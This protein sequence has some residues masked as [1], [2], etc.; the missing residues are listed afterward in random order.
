MQSGQ[1]Q[2]NSLLAQTRQLFQHQGSN[3]ELMAQIMSAIRALHQ[4]SEPPQV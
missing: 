1:T 2:S 4:L 3:A